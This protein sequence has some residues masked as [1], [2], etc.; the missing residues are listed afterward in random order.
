MV[1]LTATMVQTS[2]VGGGGTGGSIEPDA[3]EPDNSF[4]TTKFY[5]DQESQSRTLPT[6]DQDMI[7]LETTEAYEVSISTTGSIGGTTVRLLASSGGELAA[8]DTWNDFGS[9]SYAPLPAGQY[10]IEITQGYW[11]VKTPDTLSQ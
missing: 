8:G 5:L 6:G 1:Y 10:Y 11:S 2:L 7:L 9:L 3:F 4:A